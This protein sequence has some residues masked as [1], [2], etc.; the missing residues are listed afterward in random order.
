MHY[1]MTKHT[2]LHERGFHSLGPVSSTDSYYA[3]PLTKELVHEQRGYDKVRFYFDRS[4]E[5]EIFAVLFCCVRYQWTPSLTRPETDGKAVLQAA[6][7]IMRRLFPSF[8][9]EAALRKQERVRVESAG[10]RVGGLSF[11]R[12]V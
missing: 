2:Q 3:H 4:D 9:L 8:D 7:L 5:V 6:T 11:I 12:K 1:P 10:T